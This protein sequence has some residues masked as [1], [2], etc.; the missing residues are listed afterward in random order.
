MQLGQETVASL[1]EETEDE[2]KAADLK[3][4]EIATDLLGSSMEEMDMEMEEDEEPAAPKKTTPPAPGRR[5]V[6]RS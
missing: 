5:R 1:L 6:A 3:L 2:E 4:T